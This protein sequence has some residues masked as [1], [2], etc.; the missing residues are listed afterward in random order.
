[1]KSRLSRRRAIGICCASALACALAS[2]SVRADGDAIP[3]DASH[4]PDVEIDDQRV[5][6]STT[7][8]DLPA[9]G[10]ERAKLRPRLWPGNPGSPSDPATTFIPEIQLPPEVDPHLIPDVHLTDYFGILPET[11]LID[12]QTL[13][14]AH[15]RTS[16]NHALDQHFAEHDF[17]V[18]VLLFKSEQR[19]PEFQTLEGLQIRW[20][21]D[22]PGVVVGFWLGSPTRTSA[23]FGHTLRKEYTTR[24]DDAFADALGQS[25]QKT[26]PF[27]QLDHFTYSLLWRLGHLDEAETR[28]SDLRHGPHGLTSLPEFE[29]I[30]TMGWIPIA[31]GGLALALGVAAVGASAIV[32]RRRKERLARIPTPIVL[33]PVEPAERLDAPHSGGSGAVISS[34]KSSRKMPS[35]S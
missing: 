26:Y 32:V 21:G 34:A 15:E 8:L 12:P 18:Y 30:S 23:F 29:P 19:I 22:R 7:E 10:D 6:S 20:F 5:T 33:P 27:S 1:M 3:P 2:Q 14:T 11:F 25:Y 17:P 28:P 4:L 9:W 24:L 35:I 16:I 31:T 13:L